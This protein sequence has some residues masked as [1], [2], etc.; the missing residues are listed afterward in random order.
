MKITIDNELQT[1]TIHG[2]V[3]FEDLKGLAKFC[4]KNKMTKYSIQAYDEP[5]YQPFYSG[6]TLT[7]NG[8]NFVINTDNDDITGTEVMFYT[9]DTL[10]EA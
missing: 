4:K 1:I 7:T 5:T 9:T 6:G 10:G 2:M 3:T 8:E